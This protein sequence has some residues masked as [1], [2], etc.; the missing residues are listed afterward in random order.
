MDPAES[1]VHREPR[2]RPKG[3]IAKDIG[4]VQSIPAPIGFERIV[5]QAEVVDLEQILINHLRAHR[6]VVLRQVRELEPALHQLVKLPGEGGGHVDDRVTVEQ[7][8]TVAGT[9]RDP[10]RPGDHVAELRIEPVFRLTTLIQ[11]TV[12]AI[13]QFR[14][15]PRLG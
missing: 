10:A 5:P 15:E 7:V 12:R 11:L 6:E 9:R 2:G 4:L 1:P 14:D 13:Q 3:G 8:M